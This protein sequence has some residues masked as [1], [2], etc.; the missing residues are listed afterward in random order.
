M[1]GDKDISLTFAKGMA[2]LKAFDAARTH[3]SIADIAGVTGYDRA[4]VRRLVLT[5][6]HLGYVRQSGRVFSLTPRV[7]VLAGGFLQGRGYGKNVQPTL[8]AHSRHLGEAIS[9]AML[10]GLEAVYVAHGDVEDRPVS[11]GF[12]IGSRIPLLPTAIGRALLAFASGDL[13]ASALSEAPA[14]Q[15]TADTLT[16]RT[17]IGEAVAAAG[18]EGYALVDNEFEPGV[19]AL[20]IPVGRPGNV[21]AAVGISGPR[22]AFSAPAHVERARRALAD[23]AN[24]LEPLLAD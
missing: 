1:I 24:A 17:A 21:L 20:A 12:T 9:L 11:I 18:R 6:V 10:D 5:L 14:E 3:L 4:I 22:E 7:L 13:R 23:C 15:V 19:A 2:V 16:D 8:S